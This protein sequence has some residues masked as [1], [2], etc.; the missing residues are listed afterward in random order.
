[1]CVSKSVGLARAV[2]EHLL[3]LD[4]VPQGVMLISRKA[5]EIV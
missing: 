5:A 2:A 1:M 4:T 3:K